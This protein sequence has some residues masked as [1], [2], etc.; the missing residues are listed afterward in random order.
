MARLRGRVTREHIVLVE[1]PAS[2][3]VGAMLGISTASHGSIQWTP[4]RGT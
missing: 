2:Y 1:Q 3:S 4:D